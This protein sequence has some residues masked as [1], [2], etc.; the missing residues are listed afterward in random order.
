[1]VSSRPRPV[2]PPPNP[3]RSFPVDRRLVAVLLVVCALSWTVREL[4]HQKI[5]VP[6]AGTWVTSDKDSLYHMR[7]VERMLEGEGLAAR[8]P[9]LSFPD[10]SAIPWPPYYTAL[11]W[12]WTAPGAPDDPALRH[13][14]IE[15]KVASLPRLFGVA[16]SAAAALAAGALAGPGAA[17]F[18]GA[19]HALSVASVVTSRVGNGDHHA[20]VAF[21]AAVSL[22]LLSRALRPEALADARGSARRGVLLGVTAGV[23][24][25]S[26]VASVLFLLPLQ[27]VLGGMLVRHAKRPLPGLPALGTAF[28]LAALAALLP[29][30]LESPW[31]SEQPWS[32]VNLAWFH[33][34]WLLAGAAVFA[35]LLRMP[36]GPARRAWPWT[37]LAVLGGASAL[38]F[39]LDAG[40][41]AG[42]REGFAWMR[43]EDAFMGAVWESRGLF[44]AGAAFR[45]GEVLGRGY[46]LLP[47][48]WA[49]L[50]YVALRRDRFELLPLAVSCPVLFLQAARQVRFADLLAMPM[51]VLLAWGI[52]AAWRTRPLAAARRRVRA[53]GPAGEV[54]LGALLLAAAGMDHAA[55]VER[56]RAALGRDPRA[57]GQTEPPADLAAR[58]LA[59]WIRL[60]TPDSADY[61]VLASWTWGHLVEWQ[62]RR[63]SV[64]TNFGTFVGEEAFRDP[65]RFFL[66]EDPAAAEAILRRRRARY[67]MLTSWLPNQIE[68]LVRAADPALRSRYV[69]PGADPENLALRFAWYA[70]VGARLLLDGR[71]LAPDGSWAESVDFARAVHVSPGRDP[72]LAMRAGGMPAGWVWEHVPGATLEVEGAAGETLEVAVRVRYDASRYELEWVRAARAGA[73]GVARVRVPYATD[74]PNGDGMAAGPATW[75]MGAREGAVMVPARAVEEGGVLRVMR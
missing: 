21:L 3:S 19:S 28:H 33:P 71:G 32:V 60:N 46:L 65:A 74:A 35:P 6:G 51:A 73:D 49:A 24:L 31:T 14:W 67:V 8:D 42:I 63:P 9:F 62:A 25:G 61:S 39:A 7:R 12:A 27:L 38:L 45:P 4:Q 37:V 70:T 22:L 40:P 34:L 17:L 68:P 11:A 66:A 43:R 1:M 57:P 64:A 41:A 54:A 44:G 69:D 50:A 30:V 56:S 72:R 10:G 20:F 58:D 29:A 75:R 48:A 47:F 23:A 26:W 2:P 15:R 53:L 18:A 16:T 36:P 13:A 5:P 55:S 52:V 59:T